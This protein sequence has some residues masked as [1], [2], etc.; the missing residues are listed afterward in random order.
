MNPK[1]WT[2]KELLDVSVE[3]LTEKGIESP[4]LCAEILLA[5]QLNTNRVQLY[6]DFDQPLTEDEVSGYRTL[7]KRRIN[8][9]PTQ[10]ITGLQEFWSMAFRVNSDVLI[11][12]PESEILIDQVLTLYSADKN[13]GP[14]LDLGTLIG[15]LTIC[16]AK[17]FDE[18]DIYATDISQKALDIA[19]QNAKTHGVNRR[20]RFACGDLFQPFE[21]KPVS[22]DI[23]V[24]N[25]PYVTSTEL[26][27][28]E[29]EV[30]DYEPRIALDGGLD[31]LC[32]IEKII[33]KS[34]DFLNPN[35]WILIE[36]DPRH[37]EKSMRLFEE[38]R[39][40]SN[41]RRIKDYSQKYRV[42]IA[43]KID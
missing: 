35:G 29:P 3:F 41:I 30:K 22:F 19:E 13:S 17:E 26:D 2:I 37:T 15:V 20:V 34:Q 28:L 6:L 14:L 21:D 4:R 27:T 40:F 5:Y 33:V 9:E 32:Y 8:R 31:G 43:K 23:I 16:L 12:R 25:P 24:S 39:C 18:I 36:M 10:Y 1:T 42:V 38:Q 11:P 7:I